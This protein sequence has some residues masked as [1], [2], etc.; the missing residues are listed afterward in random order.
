MGVWVVLV[1]SVL[2]VLSVVTIIRTIDREIF[3]NLTSLCA[4]DKCEKL[5]VCMLSFFPPAGG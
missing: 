1:L 4:D 3:G 5:G 2:S